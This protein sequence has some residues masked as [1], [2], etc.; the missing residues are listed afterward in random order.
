M[1]K[2]GLD[3]GGEGDVGG[4]GRVDGP[5]LVDDVFGGANP[6]WG[7][8]WSLKNA[9]VNVFVVCDVGVVVRVGVFEVGDA[10]AGEGEGGKRIV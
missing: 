3:V 1:V 9:F 5:K 10:L 4:M 7:L 6:V 8:V 2:L